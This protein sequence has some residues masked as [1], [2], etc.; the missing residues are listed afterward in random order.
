VGIERPDA[1]QQDFNDH[2][3]KYIES[4]QSEREKLQKQ[5]AQLRKELDEYLDGDINRS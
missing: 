5:V 2:I 1:G 4:L 3:A